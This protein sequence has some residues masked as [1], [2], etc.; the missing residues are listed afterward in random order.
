MQVGGWHFRF[1]NR[2]A[3]LTVRLLPCPWVAGAAAQVARGL[4][5]A[6]RCAGVHDNWLDRD[7]YPFALRAVL[8]SFS[9][10][11]VAFDLR[12]E[13]AGAEALEADYGSHGRVLVVSGH[14]A[15]NRAVFR[16]F[17]DRGWPNAAIARAEFLDSPGNGPENWIWGNSDTQRVILLSPTVLVAVRR[18]LLRG[19]IVLAELDRVPP[20][21]KAIARARRSEPVSVETSIFSLAER[22]RT[23][24][25]AL[26]SRANRRGRIGLAFER[27]SSLP[28]GEAG[29]ADDCTTAYRDWLAS[30]SG[31]PV[32][33]E[34]KA[35]ADSVVQ[36]AT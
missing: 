21:S 17:N 15:L 3:W 14:F 20:A 10:Q 27:L 8:N 30:R 5:L 2:L 6:A 22:T 23:P 18:E 25:F 1:L 26:S 12:L 24:V 19:G 35:S 36:R 16:Y 32:V 31:R 4:R 13:L 33:I 9:R 34:R 7:G 29:Y 11:G 28:P